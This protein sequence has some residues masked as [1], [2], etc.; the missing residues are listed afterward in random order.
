MAALALPG[1]SLEPES[2]LAK[3]WW[4]IK[5]TWVLTDKKDLQP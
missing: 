2:S 1:I 4:A 3:F 5:D